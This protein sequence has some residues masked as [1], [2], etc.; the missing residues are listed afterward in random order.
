MPRSQQ[1]EPWLPGE[2]DVARGRG[3]HLLLKATLFVGIVAALA[4]ATLA[5]REAT[6][7]RNT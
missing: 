2:R 1:R 3:S 7:R 6:A 4:V 5:Q